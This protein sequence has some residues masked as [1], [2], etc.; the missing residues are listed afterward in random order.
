MLVVEN[1][2]V[3]MESSST[4]VSGIKKTSLLCVVRFLQ[5]ME[6]ATSHWPL[7]AASCPPGHRPGRDHQVNLAGC[8]G[9]E[10]ERV[11]G[12]C[13]RGCCA[14]CPIQI[15]RVSEKRMGTIG[16]KALDWIDKNIVAIHGQITVDS[17]Q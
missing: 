17:S 2:A 13:N 7:L 16:Q 8:A 4:T 1:G 5:L 6:V 15:A 14:K 11:A 12:R 10:S 9:V 3:M